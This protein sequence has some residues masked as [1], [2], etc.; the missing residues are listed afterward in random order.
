M[1]STDR[2][3]LGRSDW[4]AKSLTSSVGWSIDKFINCW[5]YGEMGGS[6][7]WLEKQSPECILDDKPHVTG[8]FPI[9][10][11]LSLLCLPWGE[12]F[13]STKCLLPWCSTKH[14]AHCK[15]PENSGMKL[16]KAWAQTN[17]S[18]VSS[19]VLITRHTDIWAAALVKELHEISWYTT[20]VK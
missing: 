8:Q 15:R 6:W 5:Y 2:G 11:L 14:H 3:V 16:L 13:C 4:S 18:C 7:A 12:H 1:Q 19:Q 10:L 17:L 9:A 20:V